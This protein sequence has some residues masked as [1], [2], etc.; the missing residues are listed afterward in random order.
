MKRN[1]NKTIHW[2]IAFSTIS[3]IT[4]CSEPE[5]T[6]EE[7][8]ITGTIVTSENFEGKTFH[9]SIFHA[10]SGIG[11]QQHPLY[12]CLLYTSDAADE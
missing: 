3:L 6:G 5:S 12:D 2:V 4:A 9:V 10:Q 11:F 1:I 8:S 7:M